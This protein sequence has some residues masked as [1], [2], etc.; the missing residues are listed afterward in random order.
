MSK[1]AIGSKMAYI[2]I[3]PSSPRQ[4]TTM[5]WNGFALS[6]PPARIFIPF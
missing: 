4:L 6:L 3:Y 5:S 2:I 1:L